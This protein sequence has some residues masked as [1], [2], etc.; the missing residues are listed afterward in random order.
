MDVEARIQHLQTVLETLRQLRAMADG[1]AVSLPPTVARAGGEAEIAH[2]TF[3]GMTIAEAARKY[4]GIVKASKSTGEI[5]AALEQGGLKHASEDFGTT[6]RSI[7]GRREEFIRVPN[8]DWGLTEWYPGM[9]K[10]KKAKPTSAPKKAP[11]QKRPRARK[12]TLAER[13]LST[14]KADPTAAWLPK[15]ISDAIG[16][17]NRSVQSTLTSMAKDGKIL[18]AAKGYM[19]LSTNGQEAAV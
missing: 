6:L 9:R 7:I 4:L 3:F 8:G 17:N 11:K 2:D 10:E 13:I 18:K 5:A 1:T 16:A 15:M 14:M 19:L 12:E